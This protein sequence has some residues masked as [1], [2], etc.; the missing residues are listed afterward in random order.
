MRPVHIADVAAGFCLR[1]G[2]VV[3]GIYWIANWSGNSFRPVQDDYTACS[4]QLLATA[5]IH[6]VFLNNKNQ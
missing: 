5:Q 3:F 4:R 1:L 2:A 6:F